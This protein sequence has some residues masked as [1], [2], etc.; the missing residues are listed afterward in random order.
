MNTDMPRPEAPMHD[1]A[2]EK[3]ALGSM[4]I[5][6]SAA[7]VVII[8]LEPGDFYQPKHGTIYTAIVHLMTAGQPVDPISVAHALDEKGDLVRA[9][10]APYLHELVA[11]VP[12]AAQAGHFAGIVTGWSKRRRILESAYKVAQAATNLSKPIDEVVDD[13]SRTIHKATI[14][15]AADDVAHVDDFADEEFQ[16]LRDVAAGKVEPGISTGFVDL[17][18]LLNGWQPGQLVIPAARPGAGKSILSANWALAAAETGRP[19]FMFTMEMTK[20][21][22]NQRLWS[23]VGRIPLHLFPK[24]QFDDRDWRRLAEARD[25]V[26]RL[27][28]FIDDKSNTVAAIQGHARRLTQQHGKPSLI[29]VDYLQRLTFPG[30]GDR[31]DLQVGQAA[32]DLK[33]LARD[34]AT[35]VVAVCQLNRAV[36]QRT[37]KVPQLSDLRD[38]GQ[39][40]QEADIVVLI[41]R[42]NYYD[43]ESPRSGEADLIVAKHRGGPK[44]TITVA[45]QLHL[46]RFVDIAIDAVS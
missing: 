24:A 1:Q 16:R 29:V 2:A 4:M 17:D 36:E 7:D 34:L 37:K 9:G 21:E 19:V 3:A 46:A 45:A 44:D 12:S 42:D 41:S 23:N 20:R 18:R 40:E 28:I 13:A 35:T 33:D 31:H 10:G 22:V 25:H 38:S 30:G 26:R 39:L 27:P 15:R 8:R 14:D 5:S 11:S 43:P 6:A 32:K